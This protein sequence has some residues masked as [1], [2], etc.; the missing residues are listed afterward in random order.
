MSTWKMV[1]V[2]ERERRSEREREREYLAK[3]RDYFCRTLYNA[4]LVCL[5]IVLYTA[6]RILQ[7]LCHDMCVCMCVG[8]YVSMIKR[9][10]LIGLS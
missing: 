7:S 8:V 9:K 2:S 1:V 5:C 10:P 6:A 3:E 4:L